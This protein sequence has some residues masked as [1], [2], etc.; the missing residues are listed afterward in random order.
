[1]IK[2]SLAPMAGFS[3][4][5]FREI[6]TEYHVGYTVTEM[7]SSKALVHGDRKTKDLLKIAKGED[8]VAVQLFGSEPAIMGEAAAL[9]SEMDFFMVDINMGC[10]A[11]KIVKNQCGS[12]LLEDEDLVYRIV[13]SVVEHAKKPVS[14]K[15]RKGIN[16]KLSLSAAKQIEAAGAAMITVHGRTREE[17]YTGKADW[18][19][20]KQVKNLVSIPVYGN[21]DITSLKDAI[22]K[23]EYAQV[24]G[25]SIGRGA[26][27]NP[28]LFE[29]IYCYLNH[30]PYTPPT[31]EQRL[32]LLL[33]HLNKAVEYK[34]Q[35]LGTVQM[36]KIYPYYLKSMP[37]SK[38]VRVALNHMQ[39]YR[40]C[41]SLIEQY[42]KKR[43]E[44]V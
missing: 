30:L 20:I 43:Q 23:M 40:D 8:K 26:V 18:D 7:I 12:A 22:E 15:I 34:G 27:G 10:P 3:D 44:K 38:E 25:I 4:I 11:P 42:R 2:T 1:M 5:A 31:W 9:I 37:D 29:E 21:G 39:D 33:L 16:G 35:R 36:R 14:V 6:A 28:Y 32:D 41:I 24:D 17:Y 19:Y 13:K